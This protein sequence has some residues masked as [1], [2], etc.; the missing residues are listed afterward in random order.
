MGVQHIV[1]VSELG[2]DGHEIF[3]GNTG[4]ETW[5]LGRFIFRWVIKIVKISLL[6]Y[7]GGNSDLG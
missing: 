3:S 1:Q 2:S 5:I 6:R 4:G 7:Q